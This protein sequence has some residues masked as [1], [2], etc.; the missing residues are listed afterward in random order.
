MAYTR[1]QHRRGTTAQW[2]QYDPVLGPGEIGVDLTTK[3]LKMGNGSLRWSEL[4]YFDGTAYDTAV[5]NGFE[6]TEEEWLLTLVGPPANIELGDVE[7]LPAG[8]QA[9][10][11]LTGTAPDYTISF[12]IPQG[13]QGIQGIQGE[14]GPIGPTG[15]TGIEWQGTWSSTTDYVDNDAVFY[16]GASWFAAGNPPIG[17]IPSEPSTFWFPLALQGATGPQGIQ[18]PP[19]SIS[20]LNVSSPITYDVGTSTV[21][22]D[23]DLIQ[24]IDG[25][26]A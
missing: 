15:A 22:L 11:E 14:T 23:H 19:G 2:N 25:G 5:A 1:I 13:V 17:E 26:T 24:F 3:R 16:N 20:N 4:D 8:S 21:G 10:V 9:V 12:S 18:G 6:G 7:T